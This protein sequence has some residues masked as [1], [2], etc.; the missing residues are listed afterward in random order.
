MF[1]PPINTMRQQLSDR[2]VKVTSIAANLR[3]QQIILIEQRIAQP[4]GASCCVDCHL[5]QQ[6]EVFYGAVEQLQEAR[7]SD[8][9]A[10]QFP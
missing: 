3:A 8:A 9:M 10:A 5:V 4:N 6:F 1:P 2:R 7:N